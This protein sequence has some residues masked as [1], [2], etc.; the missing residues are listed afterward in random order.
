MVKRQT[1]QFL[2][3]LSFVVSGCS[4]LWNRANAGPLQSDLVTL[5]S[6][7]GIQVSLQD[8]RMI[9]TT[10]S[11]FCRFKDEPEAVEALITEF[12][13][14]PLMLENATVPFIDAELEAGCGSFSWLL[15]GSAGHTVSGQR[16]TGSIAPPVRII[17]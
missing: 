9:G 14:A 7:H 8:C 3:L 15:E 12:K 6:H 17:L 10:R 16:Q 5:F 2:L 11:G 4:S 1:G 13:L